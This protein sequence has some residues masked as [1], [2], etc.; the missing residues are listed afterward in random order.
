[1]QVF[2]LKGLTKAQLKRSVMALI[3][4]QNRLI[5]SVSSVRVV[6]GAEVVLN[7]AAKSLILLVVSATNS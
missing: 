3:A 7:S 6:T 2:Q 4:S 5:D 1:M